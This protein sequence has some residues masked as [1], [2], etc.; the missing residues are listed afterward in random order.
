MSDHSN[1]QPLTEAEVAA[2]LD[3]IAELNADPAQVGS[4]QL[5]III[6]LVQQAHRP[7][8]AA[9]LE[10][11]I[12]LGRGVQCDDWQAAAL[13]ELANLAEDGS[14]TQHDLCVEALGTLATLED[15]EI[16]IGARVFPP[17]FRE[18]MEAGVR[19]IVGQI[20]DAEAR[21]EVLAY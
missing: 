12:T 5:S 16:L 14:S 10:R 3:Q 7:L 15:D 4:E 13:A 19:R 8:P 17:A 21:A 9:L 2:L 6:A 18:S 20:A 1:H 11:A